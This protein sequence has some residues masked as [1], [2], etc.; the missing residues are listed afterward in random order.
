EIRGKTI[1]NDS[2]NDAKAQSDS[3]RPS[4]EST[5][6]ARTVFLSDRDRQKLLRGPRNAQSLRADLEIRGKTISNDSA[7]DAK[8]QSDSRRPSPESTRPA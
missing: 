1:S 3:R 6:P 2:A 8:A 4:P 7:N 5:R